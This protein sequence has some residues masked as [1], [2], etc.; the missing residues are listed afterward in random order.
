MTKLLK[1]KYYIFLTVLG[2]SGN[3]WLG[4]VNVL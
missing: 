2:V 4:V 3:L 1:K